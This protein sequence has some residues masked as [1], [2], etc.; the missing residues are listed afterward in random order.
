[1]NLHGL[2]PVV[3]SAGLAT[4]ADP[5]VAGVFNPEAGDDALTEAVAAIVAAALTV[6]PKEGCRTDGHEIQVSYLMGEPRWVSCARCGQVWD[7]R[8]TGTTTD[9][10]NTTANTTSLFAG[11]ARPAP[12]PEAPGPRTGTVTVT[13]PAE[14]ASSPP[15]S[16]ASEPPGEA[17]SAGTACPLCTVCSSELESTV[18]SAE[19]AK[20][21]KGAVLCRSCLLTCETCDKPI[22]AD[23]GG[24][25]GAIDRAK[26]SFTRWRQRLCADC[27]KEKGQTTS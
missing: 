5:A 2:S 26:L 17:A 21:F 22:E 8:P 23:E 19:V 27:H 11:G 15:E 4:L 12:A 14:A 16:P 24:K 3:V 20:A 9:T 1:M 18:F 10:A 6:W 7:A 25:I 13:V